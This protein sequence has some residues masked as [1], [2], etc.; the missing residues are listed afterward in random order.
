MSE[1]DL[2]GNITFVNDTFA[3]LSGY[4]RQELLGKPH[5]IV[6]HPSTPKEEVFK[7]F[8]IQ[9]KMVESSK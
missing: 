8:G 2:Y 4:T 9:S 6:R 3:E 5:N 7:E 1:T